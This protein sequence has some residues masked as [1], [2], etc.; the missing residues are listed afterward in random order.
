MKEFTISHIL[1]AAIREDGEYTQLLETVKREHRASK[2]HPVLING[3]CEG[4]Q[5]AMLVS[6][7][8]DTVNERR[9]CALLICAEE[10]DC[11]RLRAMFTRYGLRAAFYVG[12]DYNFHNITAS[13]DYEH[14]RLGALVSIINGECD[15]IVTTP[16]ALLQ[17][18]M[19]QSKL[20]D[21]L[22]TLSL[23]AYCSLDE[24]KLKLINAGYRNVE[25]VDGVGQFSVRGGIL[26]IFPPGS[27]SPCPWWTSRA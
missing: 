4:A 14:E 11:V 12:R 23:G 19:P 9:S 7:L 1:P 22:F 6:L 13:H 26:D 16:D 25:M 2:P 5:D 8:R 15:A 10:R 21:S 27:E 18:T 24:T 20:K 3:L 17:Y